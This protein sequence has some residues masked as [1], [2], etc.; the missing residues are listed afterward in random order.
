[1]STN[2]NSTTRFQKGNKH[3][4][5]KGQSGN[6]KGRPK[7]RTLSEAYQRLLEDADGNGTTLADEIAQNICRIAKGPSGSAL[8]AAKEIADRSEG[9]ILPISA[10]E[11][12]IDS[13][14][15][16]AAMRIMSARNLA[17][18]VQVAESQVPPIDDPDGWAG[19]LRREVET[20]EISEE[21]ERLSKARLDKLDAVQESS[22]SCS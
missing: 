3:A 13:D 9:K 19:K 18:Y 14:L 21:A 15:L 8:A 10:A 17:R 22:D 6:P 5:K 4:W 2:S 1:M 16:E 12:Q 7:S 11:N 20:S